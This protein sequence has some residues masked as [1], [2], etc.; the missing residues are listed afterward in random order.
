[1][2]WIIL[3]LLKIFFTFYCTTKVPVKNT[4]VGLVANTGG[5]AFISMYCPA[6]TVI[7]APE[8]R[9]VLGITVVVA[10]MEELLRA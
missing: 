5:V 9:L 3:G 7:P 10:V 4:P 6:G 2:Y 1:M 8:L